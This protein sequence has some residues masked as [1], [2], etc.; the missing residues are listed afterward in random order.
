MRGEKPTRPTQEICRVRGLQDK[1]W[2][3]MQRCWKERPSERPTA[4]EIASIITEL[5]NRAVD[6]RP[7]D[8]WDDTLPSRMSY[9]LTEHPFSSTFADIIE[10]TFVQHGFT[11]AF[12]L[13]LSLKYIRLTVTLS[14]IEPCFSDQAPL[15]ASKRV[16][17]TNDSISQESSTS[18]RNR[19]ET[20]T[21]DPT[22]L[23]ARISNS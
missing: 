2:D 4:T 9:F 22:S 19:R 10:N 7:V 8:E 13:Q 6:Q 3:L 14:H 17:D 15:R 5:P 1:I 21:L 11:S 23:S 12:P 16:R 18:K 20:D